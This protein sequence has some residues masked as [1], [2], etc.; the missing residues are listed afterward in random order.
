VKAE[1]LSTSLIAKGKKKTPGLAYLG[2][3]FVY[4]VGTPPLPLL[5]E[6]VGERLRL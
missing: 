4:V 1:A 6:W 5:K 2:F 3:A